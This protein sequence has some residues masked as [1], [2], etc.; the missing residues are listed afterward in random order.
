MNKKLLELLELNKDNKVISY[1]DNKNDI[2]N[3]DISQLKYIIDNNHIELYDLK[4]FIKTGVL[5]VDDNIYYEIQN[6]IPVSAQR[7]STNYFN[8]L[9]EILKDKN[10]Y[11]IIVFDKNNKIKITYIN[12]NTYISVLKYKPA[13]QG[14]T[15]EQPMIK[16]LA[17]Y[18]K[19][20]K[21]IN[22]ILKDTTI[23]L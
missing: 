22:I 15:F 11:K 13:Y 8:K 23:K 1:S 17:Q 20:G 18:L 5:C 19:N 21:H 12:K 6:F 14:Y 2:K 10:N 4:K 9:E 3:Y 7:Q 16:Q